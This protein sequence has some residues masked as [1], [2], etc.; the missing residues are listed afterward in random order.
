MVESNM[1]VGDK[2]S[3]TRSWIYIEGIALY[4]IVYR[5]LDCRS[6]NMLAL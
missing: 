5:L 6:R 1:V 3:R 4:R 2:H